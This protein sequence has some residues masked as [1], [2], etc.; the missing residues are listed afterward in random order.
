M[1][2]ARNGARSCDGADVSGGTT[3]RADE[4]R[5]RGADDSKN[6]DEATD[7]PYPTEPAAQDGMARMIE[8]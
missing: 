6:G 1:P 8:G 7:P 5:A 4:D 2:A 3:A